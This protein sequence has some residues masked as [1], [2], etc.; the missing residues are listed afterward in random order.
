MWYSLLVALAS[1][2]CAADATCDPSPAPDPATLQ[3]KLIELEEDI[4]K[5][6]REAAELRVQLDKLAPRRVMILTPQEAVEAFKKHPDQPV[7]VEFGVL[8][9]SAANRTGPVARPSI[10]LV[11]LKE[12]GAMRTGPGIGGDPI[13]ATWDGYL[14]GG[15][16]FTVTLTARAYAGLK[17]PSN[18]P[19]QPAVAPPPGRER[20]AIGEH[21]DDHGLRVTG[22]VRRAGGAPFQDNYEMVIDDPSSV[23]LF[24]GVAPK[25]IRCR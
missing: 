10:D 20:Q 18:A 3:K 11:D 2:V 24:T 9:G 13:W 7:T 25:P 21:I 14:I 16:Q 1:L 4:A 15:G 8:E 5:L 22:L 12:P 23:A 17:I 6:Q 19:G